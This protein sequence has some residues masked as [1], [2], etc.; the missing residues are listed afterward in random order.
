MTSTTAPPSPP[1]PPSSRRRKRSRLRRLTTTDKVLLTLFIGLPTALHLFLIWVPTVLSA[2]LSFSSW[3]GISPL[4]ELTWVGFQNYQQIATIY[5]SFWPAVQHNV[6][7]LVFFLVVAYLLDKELRGTRFYQSAIF[8]PVVLS[9]AL[10]G[11][12]WE[13]VYKDQTGLLNNLI[14]ST[15]NSDFH[16]Q[17]LA[18]ED[19]Y[20]NL[21]AVLIAAS[22]RHIGYIMILFLAGL[23]SV[24]PALREAA[25]IDGAT[26]WQTFRHVVFPALAPVNIVVLVVTIIDSL[27][28]YDI[29]Y[30]I[31]GGRNGLELVGI[32]ITDN[33][34]GEAS[35]IGYGSALA[36]ILF[37][38]AMTVILPYL[39]RTFRKD[40][41]R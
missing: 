38:I 28:A 35:R 39:V 12:I 41:A 24:D 29:V 2:V 11:F 7:W 30:V 36:V 13:L 23:K 9:A 19:Y 25:A 5:P 33:V 4:D 26:E 40:L 21:F 10:V 6:I 17:W 32:L 37:I 16:R 3:D 18:E 22:W 1:A 14:R 27:R 31:N 8:V 15:V 34:L 20:G